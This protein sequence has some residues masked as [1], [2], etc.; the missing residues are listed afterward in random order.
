MPRAR[1][2]SSD[3]D[4]RRFDVRAVG[5]LDEQESPPGHLSRPHVGGA[6]A[7][8]TPRPAR[9]S[10]NHRPVA[11]APSNEKKMTRLLAVHVASRAPMLYLGH[12]GRDE[13]VPLARDR[14]RVR[15]LAHGGGGEEAKRFVGT[16]KLIPIEDDRG[17]RWGHA[18]REWSTGRR[19]R[20][21]GRADHAGPA[22]REVERGRVTDAPNRQNATSQLHRLFR[23]LHGRRKGP[24]REPSPCGLARS[25]RGRR[26][27]SAALRV[28]SGRPVDPD[29][30]R[31]SEDA[32]HL[33]ARPLATVGFDKM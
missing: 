12:G 32:T 30:G 10:R 9:D 1:A 19:G 16:R 11:A 13:K 2:L 29:A 20:K 5:V 28:R 3:D 8:P 7:L 6:H 17:R 27:R 15:V 14:S 18:R 31:I 4:D 23:N 21:H 25:R 24:Y 26:R 22:A 33:G